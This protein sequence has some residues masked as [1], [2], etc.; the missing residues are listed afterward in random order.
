MIVV[1]AECHVIEDHWQDFEEKML[2]LTQVVRSESGC[3]RYDI[4]T[5]SEEPGL[6]IILEEWESQDHLDA[7]LNTT[8]MQEHYDQVSH[9]YAKPVQ[10]TIYT[11]DSCEKAILS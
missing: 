4:M 6:F 8:H 1:V 10:L 11:V 9:W 3:L 5:S 2:A 7:H